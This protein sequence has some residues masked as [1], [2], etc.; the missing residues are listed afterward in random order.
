MS[1]LDL[2]RQLGILDTRVDDVLVDDLGP[3]RADKVAHVGIHVR[4]QAKQ[5]GERNAK[6]CITAAAVVPSA[7]EGEA[8]T[9][10]GWSYTDRRWLPYHQAAAAFH[11]TDYPAGKLTELDDSIDGC[12]KAAKEIDLALG[13]LRGFIGTTAYTVMVDAVATRR[14]WK[15]LQNVH[16]GETPH[17]GTTWLPG[18]PLDEE[19]KP[20]AV[21]R[22]NKSAEVPAPTGVTVL[23]DGIATS[24]LATTSVFYQ[25][26]PDLKNSAWYLSNVPH[27]F[28]GSGSGRMGEKKTRWTAVFGS[29][30]DKLKSEVSPNWYTM[31]ATEI[32]PVSTA[33]GIDREALASLAARL[34]HKPLAWAQRTRYPLP[35]HA[36]QQMDLDHPQYR[37]TAPNSAL[38]EAD[39]MEEFNEADSADTGTT[40]Q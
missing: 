1:L 36:A 21:V 18:S 2:S 22:V 6:M 38:M 9:M 7:L 13:E 8:W 20:F 19:Q 31:N 27:Q 29:K 17:T 30:E 37:R 15:G 28:D 35:L 32:Y 10:Y 34:C 23:K 26:T 5:K 4:R 33:D 3:H 16:Q 11:A 24:K 12:V 25:A 14:L 40:E 39:S